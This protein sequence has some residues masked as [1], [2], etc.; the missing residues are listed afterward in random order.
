MA[1]PHQHGEIPQSTSSAKAATSKLWP[2]EP[3]AGNHA[4]VN[5]LSTDNLALDQSQNYLEIFKLQYLSFFPFVYIPQTTTPTQLQQERPL[6]WMSIQAICTRSLAQ[7][8]ALGTQIREI[9]VKQLLVDG[10]R[11]I[12]LLLCLLAFLAWY[13]IP[14]YL[15]LL[16]LS[17]PVVE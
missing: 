5:G 12:D 8:E 15:F 4:Q 3:I 1:S 9:L 17:H 2:C 16:F 14:L 6:L 13:V 11:N 7:Q 10:E